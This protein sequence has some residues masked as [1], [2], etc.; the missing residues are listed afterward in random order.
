MELSIK[1]RH[2]ARYGEI[3]ALLVKH[4]LRVRQANG[5][6]LAEG[7]EL[8]AVDEDDVAAA[9]KLAAS[10]ESMGPTFVK[11]GQLLSTRADLLPPVYL[12]AL[13]RLQ[14]EVE[15]FGFAAVEEIVTRELGVRLSD[16]FTFFDHEPLAAASLGQVHR[17]TLRSGRDVAVKVQR[18]DIRDQIVD[19]MAVIA[20]LAAFVDEHTQLGSD[21][22]FSAMVTEFRRSLLDELDYRHEAA[23]LVLLRANLADYPQL[24]VPA[25]VDDYTTSLVL[26]MEFVP[27]RNVASLG[28]LAQLEIDGPALTTA[29][30]DAYLDQILVDGFFHADPHP[31]NILL[32]DDGRLALIDLGMA[33]RVQAPLQD[34]LVRLLIAVGE[35][36]GD[37]AAE[38]LTKIGDPQPHFDAAAFTAGCVDLLDEY[39][40]A[41]LEQIQAGRLVGE[42]ARTSAAAG[43]RPPRELTMVSKALLNLDEVA[44]RLAPTFDPNAE[45]RDH[46]QSIMQ[47]KMAAGASPGNL[48]TAALDAKEFAEHLPSRVNKVMDAL[49]EGELTLNVQGI[50]DA[51]LMRGIQ[52]IANRVTAG[53]ITAALI[54]GASLFGRGDARHELFGYPTLSIILLGLAA[55]AGVWLLWSTFRNDLP[56]RRRPGRP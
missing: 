42:L 17:A 24:I 21:L 3:G 56:Q 43:L 37:R 45:I 12:D 1:P 25:P 34:Q 44:R 50:D 55:S 20:E 13:A 15:P 29:L 39:R 36:R 49:A 23:N 26:T 22:G 35:G 11:L 54:L 51:E 27:G 9:E 48:L 10:L 33:A 31:G 40:T 32:T 53:V 4:A 2:V 16:A 47:R 14:D 38:V 8:E 7:D 18:P 6:V 46:L 28:P 30:F 41:R 5:D 52:K 19:D